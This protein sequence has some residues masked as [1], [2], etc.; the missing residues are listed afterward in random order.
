MLATELRTPTPSKSSLKSLCTQGFASQAKADGT[1]KDLTG[2]IKHTNFL[3]T[4]D[5]FY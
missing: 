5:L 2:K 4:T 3:I 1:R